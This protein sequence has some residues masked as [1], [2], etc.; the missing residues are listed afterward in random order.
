VSS[1]NQVKKI[2]NTEHLLLLVERL[3]KRSI[4]QPFIFCHL[5]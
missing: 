2:Q 1:T 5:Y 3:Q 4:G